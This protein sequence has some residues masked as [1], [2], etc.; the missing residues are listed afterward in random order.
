MQYTKAIKDDRGKVEIKVDLW[1]GTYSS[2][3]DRNGN[4]F[5]YDISTMV[6]PKGKRKPIYFPDDA[7]VATDAEI[8]EAKTELWNLIKPKP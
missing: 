8:L 6:T 1:I 7:H 4:R 3:K 2:D 5:R